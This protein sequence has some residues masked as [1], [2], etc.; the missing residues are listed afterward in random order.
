[1]YGTRRINVT[2]STIVCDAP[3]K[4]FVLYTKSHIGFSNCSKC[5]IIWEK[6]LLLQIPNIGLISAVA[7]DYMHLV[8]L[9]VTNKLLLLW[10]KEPLTVRIDNTNINLIFQ[11]FDCTEKFNTKRDFEKIHKSQFLLYTG[12]IV[13]KSI[14]KQEIYEYFLTLHIAILIIS[15]T[16]ITNNENIFQVLYSKQF[17]LHKVHNLIHLRNEV[18]RNGILDNFSAFQ[19]E[20]FLGSLKK[21]IRI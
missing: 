3:A 10:M 15:S 7:L 12:P 2:L 6:T 4:S 14:L 17:V 13:S 1:M 9:G 16:L 11:R 20:N 18:R 5:T 19:F 21:L 8:C